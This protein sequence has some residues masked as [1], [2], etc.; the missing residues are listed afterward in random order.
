MKRIEGLARLPQVTAAV[1]RI[2]SDNQSGAAEIL[3]SSAEVFS[4]LDAEE[5]TDAEE[6]RLLVIETGIAL[7]RAQ[8]FMAPLTNLASKAISAAL[9]NPD[10]AT[11]SAAEAA[12]GFISEAERATGDAASRAADLIKNGAVVLTHSR[13]STVLGAFTCARSRGTRFDVFAT[14]SRP[15]L[16]GR[17]LA[18]EL[19]REGINVSVIA[20]AA[21]A[22]VMDRARMV[23]LGAD[24]VTPE[25]VVNKIGTRMIALAARER[26][27]AVYAIA[28]TS[29][30][31][32]A[33]EIIS[34][35][36]ERRSAEELW[37][38]APSQV[39]VL[40]YYFE[41]TPLD[42]FTGIIAEDGLLLSEEAARRAEAMT[43]HPLLMDALG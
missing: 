2:A 8:P 26:G 22:F 43:I 28:D 41:P 7:V 4:L 1:Q 33:A 15:L 9:A 6:A 37:P 23:L 35:A 3:R 32:N 25:C 5:I 14:E 10:R 20:D 24:K 42:Y 36:G 38:D 16:E 30:F 40:N 11:V 21:A 18:S 27:L 17:T 34:A 29:K 12:E 19:V 31:I 13:S 39:T